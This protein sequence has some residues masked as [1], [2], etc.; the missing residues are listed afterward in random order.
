MHCEICGA[1]LGRRGRGR[2]PK[3]CSPACRQRAFAARTTGDKAQPIL[4]AVRPISSIS[5]GGKPN[6]INGASASQ[7]RVYRGG[8]CGPKSA[9]R[10]EVISARDWQE[11]ISDSGVVSYVSRLTKPALRDAEAA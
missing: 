2:A 5:L 3:Y 9:I 4:N 7:N 10:A 11:I 1:P 8:I 6:E